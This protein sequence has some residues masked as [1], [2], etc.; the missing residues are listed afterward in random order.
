MVVVGKSVSHK[1]Q[2]DRPLTTHHSPLTTHHSPL[3][4]DT[5]HHSPKT[6]MNPQ[7]TTDVAGFVV[8]DQEPL[9]AV[10][11][12][13]RGPQ[14]ESPVSGSLLDLVLRS[15]PTA[16]GQAGYR[17]DQFLAE[18]SPAEPWLVGSA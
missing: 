9:P 5:T 12:V 1:R 8:T 18:P 2:K 4:N 6:K 3:T 17:L 11:P 16:N 13:F 14:L 7:P 15:T 10:A